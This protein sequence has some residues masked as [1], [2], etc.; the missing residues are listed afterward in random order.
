LMTNLSTIPRSR[1]LS[2]FAKIMKQDTPITWLPSIKATPNTFAKN[3]PFYWQVRATKSKRF[4]KV[5]YLSLKKCKYPETCWITQ[6]C[7]KNHQSPAFYQAAEPWLKAVT[8]A[9]WKSRIFWITQKVFWIK[10]N[11]RKSKSSKTWSNQNN[12]MANRSKK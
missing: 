8:D 9:S 11:K 5:Q 7:L 10:L 1:I 6:C 2:T 4:P 12:F 3:V